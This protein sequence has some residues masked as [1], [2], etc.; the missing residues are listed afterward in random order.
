MDSTNANVDR[1]VSFMNIDCYQHASDVI[2]CILEVTADKQYTNLF[3]EAFKAKIPQCYYE[4]QSDE[5][6]LY[7]VCASVFYIEELFEESAH[8]AGLELMKNCEYQ[9]C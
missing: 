6:V 7:H 8:E 5:K 2:G 1:Y 9:C 3:W 4:H